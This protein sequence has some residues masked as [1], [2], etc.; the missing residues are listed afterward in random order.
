M[1]TFLKY[2]FIKSVKNKAY[3]L[4]E[5]KKR[6][7]I[8]HYLTEKATLH[9]LSDISHIKVLCTVYTCYADFSEILLYQ[10]CES[11]AYN[12]FEIRERF[13]ILTI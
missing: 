4:L 12:L 11:K 7:E 5:V 8:L 10:K 6:F 2:Y 9:K 13:E 1:L 3:N